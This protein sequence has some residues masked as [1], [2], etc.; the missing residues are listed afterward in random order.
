M[1]EEKWEKVENTSGGSYCDLCSVELGKV[2]WAL[3]GGSC[4]I[5]K[6][7][8]KDIKDGLK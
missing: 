5:C 4:T 7:C 6:D 1:G 8:L 2:Y 3:V